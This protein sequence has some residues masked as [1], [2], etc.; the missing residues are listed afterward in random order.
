MSGDMPSGREVPNV[1]ARGRRS[2]RSLKMPTSLFQVRYSGCTGPGGAAR[3]GARVTSGGQRAVAAWRVY[4]F[5]SE[6]NVATVDALPPS[7]A[8]PE[9]HVVLEDARDKR[10]AFL[11]RSTGSRG[12]PSTAP[13][14][15]SPPVPAPGRGRPALVADQ[16]VDVA[17][18]T[19]VPAAVLRNR[20]RDAFGARSRCRTERGEESHAGPLQLPDSKGVVVRRG[21]VPR[22]VTVISPSR[23]KASAYA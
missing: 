20:D 4:P 6:A 21:A 13:P 19:K 10:V 2:A 1:Y 8:S 16:D 3:T 15:R 9:R 7:P 18:L 22:R 11:I 14:D 23:S 17:S 5:R 12:R